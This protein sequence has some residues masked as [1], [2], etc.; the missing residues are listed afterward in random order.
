MDVD[1]RT[2]QLCIAGTQAEFARDLEAAKRLFSEAWA[3][4]VDDYDAALA[5]HYVAHLEPDPHEA[6]R[7]NLIALEKARLDPRADSFMGSLLVSLGG[8]Y[9]AVGQAAEAERYFAL[10][11]ERGVEH[12]RG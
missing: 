9:E 12:Y 10:A 1:S 6:L 8:A 7:W 5:A 3:A 4:A 11:S 2:A